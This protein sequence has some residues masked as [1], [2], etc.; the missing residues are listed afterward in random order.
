MALTAGMHTRTSTWGE[1]SCKPQP[2]TAPSHGTGNG[3]RQMWAWKRST[4]ASI[5]ARVI[6]RKVRAD[7]SSSDA[8]LYR[9][10]GRLAHPLS[11]LH[12]CP[13]VRAAGGNIAADARFL[14]G[15]LG[16]DRLFRLGD[17]GPAVRPHG[18]L[19][20]RH[21]A[22]GRGRHLSLSPSDIAD[23]GRPGHCAPAYPVRRPAG[24]ARAAQFHPG[25]VARPLR[26]PVDLLADRAGG[27]GPVARE[28]EYP[29]RDLASLRTSCW[30]WS[31]SRRGWRIW[32]GGASTWSIPG[33]GR[34]GSA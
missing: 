15:V 27:D 31:P 34:C 10:W 20:A 33:S 22:V 1:R 5:R 6:D 19:P 12:P 11:V 7:A 30:R 21:R 32:W 14:D 13:A 18:A 29:L 26:R 3:R 2:A 4:R 8:S 9:A 28:V 17:D 25:A 16:R 23:S 24:I